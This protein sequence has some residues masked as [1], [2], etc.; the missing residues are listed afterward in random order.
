[1]MD[2]TENTAS[3]EAAGQGTAPRPPETTLP[4]TRTAGTVESPCISICT[5]DDEG[6]CLGCFRTVE[7]IETWLRMDADRRRLVLLECDRRRA[8]EGVI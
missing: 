2:D 1:M 8:A 3:D 5:L 6:M 7:E 4:D